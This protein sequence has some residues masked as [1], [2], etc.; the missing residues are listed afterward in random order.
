M[1]IEIAGLAEQGVKDIT[2][3]GQN[4]NAYRGQMAEGGIADFALRIEFIALV[5][6]LSTLF[7]TPKKSVQ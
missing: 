6:N 4:V 3:L 5:I 2:L 7:S 1:L